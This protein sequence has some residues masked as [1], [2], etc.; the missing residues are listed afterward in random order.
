MTQH[1]KT[2]NAARIG[3]EIG[4]DYIVSFRGEFLG[5]LIDAVALI[6]VL[7]IVLRQQEEGLE[8]SKTGYMGI[9]ILIEQIKERLD[10]NSNLL[11]DD[12]L[13]SQQEIAQGQGIARESK[14]LE[15]QYN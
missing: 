4:T 8:L 14:H 11:P 5:K 13:D 7:E 3:E 2:P 12:Y 9:S 15:R 6:D 1:D 10:I